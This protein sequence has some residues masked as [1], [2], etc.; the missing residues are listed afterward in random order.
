MAKSFEIQRS[1]FK[2][3]TNDGK[4]I[5]EHFGKASISADISVAHM[6][7]PP[8]W[9]EPFQCPEFDEYTIIIRG[10][11]QIIVED[12][13]II[14]NAGSSI[15]VNKGV[16]VKYSNPFNEVCEYIA[17]CKPP[18]TLEKSNRES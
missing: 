15:K 11:K 9:E 2:V 13:K 18:F 1:P 12:E 16:R 5:L 7:A 17:I 3:P 14:L 6:I 10:K 8:G 4:V